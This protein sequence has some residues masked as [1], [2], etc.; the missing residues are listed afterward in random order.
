MSWFI[1]FRKYV[2]YKQRQSFMETLYEGIGRGDVTRKEGD[3]RGK[4][5]GSRRQLGEEGRGIQHGNWW[6]DTLETGSQFCHGSCLFSSVPVRARH[7]NPREHFTSYYFTSDYR[8]PGSFPKQI[9]SILN[10]PDQSVL[11]RL[12]ICYNHSLTYASLHRPT[13]LMHPAPHFSQWLSNKQMQQHKLYN[14]R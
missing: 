2:H 11:L 5:R 12:H 6:R 3:G 13:S 7:G 14:F 8:D 9:F 4:E 1:L 10:V